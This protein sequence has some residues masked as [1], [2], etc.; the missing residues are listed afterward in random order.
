MT[1]SAVCVGQLE[2]LADVE[3]RLIVLGIVECLLEVD[4]NSA[5]VLGLGTHIKKHIVG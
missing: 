5:I 4:C 2:S 1:L 3:S